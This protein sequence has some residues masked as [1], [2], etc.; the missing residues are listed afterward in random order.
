MT[1]IIDSKNCTV[2]YPSN[3][4]DSR[5]TVLNDITLQVQQGEFVTVVGSSGCGK[6]TVLRLVLGSQFPTEGV[7]LVNGKSVTRVTRDTGIVY[8]NYSLF[9]HLTMLENI[10]AGPILE[11]TNLPERIICKP[12]VKILDLLKATSLLKRIPYSRIRDEARAQALVLAERCGLEPQKNGNKYPF[13]LSG[14]MR[15]RVAIAQSLAM[16][17]SILLM[18][19]AFSGL[20]EKTKCEMRDFIHEQ[21]KENKTTIFFVTHDLE[22]AAMLGTRLI[23]LSQHWTDDDGN[24]GKGAKIVIDKQVAGGTVRPSKFVDSHEFTQLV[25]NIRAKAF[26][27]NN[28]Q[29]LAAFELSHPD[30]CKAKEHNNAQ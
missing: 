20:D 6:S 10:A 7:V 23:C 1:F 13:E 3:K 21:W 29:R 2:S 15:Q 26:E 5:A 22:E 4:G 8:Q 11:G 24:P 18:D 16:K 25:D 27:K 30:A 12:L 17:P 28:P 14:G 19:E 9:P